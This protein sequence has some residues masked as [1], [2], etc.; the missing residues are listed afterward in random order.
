MW[1]QMQ[2]HSVEGSSSLLLLQE[3]HVTCSSFF[4]M[5]WPSTATSSQAISFSP[6]LQIL[7][8]QRSRMSFCQVRLQPI[9]PMSS[10][11]HSMQS[12]GDHQRHRG[13]HLWKGSRLC[14]HHRVSETGPPSH[15]LYHLS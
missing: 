13:W 1:M 15:A 8:G 11:V 6:L 12:R 3:A 9:A 10:S 2:S 4:R 5:H 14:V 7:L